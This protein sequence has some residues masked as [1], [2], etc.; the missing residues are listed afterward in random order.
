MENI[1]EPKK[2]RRSK[3]PNPNKPT[4]RAF[5]CPLC[6]MAFF[7]L[8][9]QTRHMRTHTGE[10][11]HQCQAPNCGKR[12]SRTDEL[13]RHTR[14]HRTDHVK[15]QREKS[16]KPKIPKNKKLCNTLPPLNSH[17][18]QLIS[19]LKIEPNNYYSSTKLQ[20]IKSAP[21]TQQTDDSNLIASSLQK[22]SEYS[23]QFGFQLQQNTNLLIRPLPNQN[24]Q[25]N[26]MYQNQQNQK[27]DFL[28]NLYGNNNSQSGV[29]PS[30]LSMSA[31]SRTMTSVPPFFS[32]SSS[33]SDF[34][35][36]TMAN[37]GANQ[38]LGSQYNN[39][40]QQQSQRNHLQT[41]SNYS[42]EPLIS[43]K[44]L[45]GYNYSSGRTISNPLS[46]NPRQ[47]YVIP[48]M[49]TSS[50]TSVPPATNSSKSSSSSLASAN[51]I[52]EFK[53]FSQNG[54][55]KNFAYNSKSI[56]CN[57][58]KM[59][60]QFSEQSLSDIFNIPL[61]NSGISSSISDSI[62]NKRKFETQM[63]HSQI[64]FSKNEVSGS[65]KSKQ[66]DI[67]YQNSRFEALS[68]QVNSSDTEVSMD[69]RPMIPQKL[70]NTNIDI[71]SQNSITSS[72]DPY[73]LSLFDVF[74][75]D[76]KYP[77]SDPSQS[78]LKNQNINSNDNSSFDLFSQYSWQPIIDQTNS[79]LLYN[80][81]LNSQ[82]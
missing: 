38:G 55:N 25:Q 6:P 21:F 51:N 7:R 80:S 67:H 24:Y 59:N 73:S 3:I 34:F 78:L 62:Q 76:T 35:H 53:D 60:S 79:D 23:P 70:S 47:S 36:Y 61:P 81:I 33:S 20:L 56:H 64:L 32:S 5:K 1:Q 14:I 57:Q 30:S 19:P 18:N 8:E 66:N 65:L 52:S 16:N 46:T 10:K 48:Q 27:N 54:L 63:S 40:N 50:S 82:K 58:Q 31:N 15:K 41:S 43:S 29:D 28:I 37:S 49:T 9:H 4:I 72:I 68:Q 2:R 11:P 77:N 69:L 45:S 75:K 71:K 22:F 42:N 17:K 39:Y 44:S 74:G 13:T 26:S 12:F